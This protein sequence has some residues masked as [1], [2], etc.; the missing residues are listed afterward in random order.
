M[1]EFSRRISIHALREEGDFGGAGRFARFYK[2]LSTPS[3][4]RATQSKQVSV[5]CQSIS[6]HALREEGDLLGRVFFLLAS[7]FLS[8]PS[9]RRATLLAITPGWQAPIS[10]HALREEGDAHDGSRVDY[11]KHFYPRPP[12]GGRPGLDRVFVAHGV[13]LSTPSARRATCWCLRAEQAW[14]ISIHALREEGDQSRDILALLL[15]HFYPRPPR[16]GRPKPEAA[17]SV[18]AGFLSTPSARRATVKYG[19]L[20]WLSLYFYPRPPRGGRH[21]KFSTTVTLQVFLSTPSARRATRG[22]AKPPGLGVISI[23]ALREEGDVG[24]SLLS[25]TQSH[26]YPRPPRGGRLTSCLPYPQ[27]GPISIHALREEGDSPDPLRLPSYQQFLSTP[28][29]RRATPGCGCP[30]SW[31]SNFYPRPP[32]GGRQTVAPRHNGMGDFYPRPP[33]GGRR[34][35]VIAHLHK[36]HFYPRPPRGGRPEERFNTSCNLSISIHA[37]REEGDS[38]VKVC[39]IHVVNFY[40]RP[41]RGGRRRCVD[42]ERVPR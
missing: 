3:A 32:R 38:V 11:D 7:E 26:F 13:F 31:S 23:H 41:P 14:S 18:P 24:R 29:A 35:R 17:G 36:H 21:T 42:G 33:R 27:R 39:L 22:A 4:R 2:F 28:S 15:M 12:R 16:G 1:Q 9:A 6:I 30:M 5:L 34:H 25:K 37:L 8:T 20:S 19:C 40:P 10:I